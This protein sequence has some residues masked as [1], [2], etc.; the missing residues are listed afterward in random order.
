MSSKTFKRQRVEEPFVMLVR[1]VIR[2]R[3]YIELSSHAKA[4]LVDVADMYNGKN[5]GDLSVAWR[6]MQPR[7]WKSQDTLNTAKQEL[8]AA[9][10]LFETRK[11]GRPN[12]ASLYALTWFSLNDNSKFDASAKSLFKKGSYG[13][14]GIND[15]I[16]DLPD[17]HMANAALVGRYMGVH[18]RTV[19]RLASDRELPAPVTLANGMQRWNLGEV[20]QHLKAA[21]KAASAP[22]AGAI[23][24]A[25]A[26]T[27][28]GARSACIAP[29]AVLEVQPLLRQP[30]QS[31]PL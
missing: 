31:S 11:G 10:F 20:R 28:A 29:P 16:A 14:V 13:Q 9:G 1:S 25:V 12:R 30:E 15:D 23:P 3:A 5:N 22:V 4:L 19:H 27:A 21:E 18:A 8:L 26:T 7:G 2:S 24:G 6:L 17:S